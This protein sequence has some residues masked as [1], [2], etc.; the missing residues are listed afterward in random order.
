MK[1]LDNIETVPFITHVP[2][3]TIALEINAKMFVNGKIQE[4][5][6]TLDSSDDIREGMIQGD[7]WEAENVRYVITDE[8]RKLLDEQES[9]DI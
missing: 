1:E 5:T 2:K 8:A 3:S 4:A 6:M 7:D 9:T